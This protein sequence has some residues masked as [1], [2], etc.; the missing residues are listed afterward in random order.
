MAYTFTK[1]YDNMILALMGY[2]S[3]TSGVL[4][5]S[6]YL[7]DTTVVS[8]RFNAGSK[9]STSAYFGKSTFAAIDQSGYNSY[10]NFIN[11]Y[12]LTVCDGTGSVNYYDYQINSGS[13]IIYSGFDTSGL[14]QTS[15]DYDLKLSQSV[16]PVSLTENGKQYIKVTFQLR[17]DGTTNKTIGEICFAPRCRESSQSISGGNR[18]LFYHEILDN[19][20]TLTPGEFF[21]YENKIELPNF[22]PNKPSA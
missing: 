1:N 15:N 14:N 11:N 7:D 22:R 2:F 21:T 10:Y 4:S 12:A 3:S 18:F 8:K 17:N 5:E 9:T 13:T 19:P 6:S 16:T 20:V